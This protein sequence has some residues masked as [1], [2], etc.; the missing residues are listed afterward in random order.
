[1]TGFLE[2]GAVARELDINPNTLRTWE[3][4][5]RSIVPHR[6]DR[7]QRLYDSEQIAMLRRVQAQV[8]RGSRAGAAHKN[9]VSS[10]PIRMSRF[11]LEPTHGAPAEARRAVE[12]LLEGLDAP[13]FAFY[14]RLVASELVNNA[15]IHGMTGAPIRVELRLFHKWA[16]LCVQNA[17]ARLSMKRLRR[18]S[19][20]EGGR[21]LEIIDVLAEAWSIHTGPFGTKVTVRLPVKAR[22]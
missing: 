20:Q 16:D 8:R 12:A 9:A 18:R 10:R 13:E 19:R 17:G 22:T 15:V 7:G 4:R 11:T 5:Y 14:L 2:I 21:G 6:G 1:M 3:R